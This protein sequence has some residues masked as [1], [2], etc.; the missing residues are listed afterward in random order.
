LRDLTSAFT[1]REAIAWLR[2]SR[3]GCIIGPQQAYLAQVRLYVSCACG[4][5][6]V[7]V[8]SA[9]AC[10]YV[11]VRVSV[12]FSINGLQQVYREQ[13]CVCARVTC[14]CGHVRVRVVMCVCI[15]LFLSHLLV[16]IRPTLSTYV[17]LCLCL[18]LCLCFRCLYEKC[19]SCLSLS[20]F[21]CLSCPF[22]SLLTH[23][24]YGCVCLCGV[25][26]FVCTHIKS[27]KKPHR[28]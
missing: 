15:L 17:C 7:R 5:L 9:C 22:P 14:A 2:I 12:S 21:S 8:A 20:A 3:P 25:C 24:V 10:G 28:E 13:V 1:A 16:P 4:Y 27:P 19:E 6:H 11:H 26:M 23:F 18:C